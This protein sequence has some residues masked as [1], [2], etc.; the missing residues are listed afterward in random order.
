MGGSLSTNAMVNYTAEK[1][2]RVD[3]TFGIGYGDSTD[4]A[5]EVILGILATNDKILADPAVFV[6]VSALADSSVNFAV[7]AWTKTEDYWDVYFDINT[8]VY[9]QFDAAGLNIPYPQMDVHVHQS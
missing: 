5:K 9:N 3:W 4:K 8:K 6:E 7:R 2:R 1:T